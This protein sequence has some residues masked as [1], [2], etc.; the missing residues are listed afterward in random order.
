MRKTVLRTYDEVL[1]NLCSKDIEMAERTTVGTGCGWMPFK[2]L[3]F[4]TRLRFFM[5]VGKASSYWCMVFV[6]VIPAPG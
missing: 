6:L 2:M 4:Q 1:N 5:C 3:Y